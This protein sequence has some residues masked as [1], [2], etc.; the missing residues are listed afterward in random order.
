MTLINKEEKEAI[1]RL[2]PRA[3]I[4]RTMKNKSNRHRYYVEESRSVMYHLNKMRDKNIVQDAAK[5]SVS[6]GS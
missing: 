3:H 6:D 2:C 5:G 4:V 1:S